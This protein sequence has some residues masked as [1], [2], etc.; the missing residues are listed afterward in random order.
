ME[1]TKTMPADA[2]TLSICIPTYNR[3]RYL[4]NLLKELTEIGRAHV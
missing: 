1:P 4:E 3:A 2:I